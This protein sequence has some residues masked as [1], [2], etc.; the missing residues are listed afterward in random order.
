[1]LPAAPLRQLAMHAAH[2][3]MQATRFPRCISCMHG[4]SRIEYS[5]STGRRPRQYQN[6]LHAGT[7]YW[8]RHC[9]IYWFPG[10]RYAFPTQYMYSSTLY[11]SYEYT[12]FA[13]ESL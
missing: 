5:V 2:T 1:L 13:T 6:K 11:L 12:R 7:F 9:G 3:R 4:E 8:Y 10:S